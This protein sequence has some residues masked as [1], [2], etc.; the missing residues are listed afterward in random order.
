MFNLEAAT[1]S[2]VYSEMSLFIIK[3]PAGPGAR[4]LTRWKFPVVQVVRKLSAALAAGC[5]SIVK[6]PEDLPLIRCF[7]GAGVASDLVDPVYAKPV[8]EPAAQYLWQGSRADASGRA[9]EIL[10]QHV[11]DG[12]E[13]EAV[14]GDQIDAVGND[15]IDIAHQAQPFGQIE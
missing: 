7:T 6:T 2:P 9:G 11:A 15:C 14:G 10:C 8:S 4:L 5:S 1:R 3:E 12:F 13:V